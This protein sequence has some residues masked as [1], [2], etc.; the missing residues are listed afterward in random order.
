MKIKQITSKAISIITAVALILSCITITLN[1]FAAPVKFNVTSASPAIPLYVG[2]A[3]DLKNLSIQIGNYT[4]SGDTLTWTVKSGSSA[5]CQNGFLIAKSEGK[6]CFSVSSGGTK[7]NVW[8]I[9]NDSDNLDFSLINLDFSSDIYNKSDWVQ[10]SVQRDNTEWSITSGQHTVSDVITTANAPTRDGERGAIILTGA[11]NTLISKAAFYKSDIMEDFG[12]YTVESEISVVMAATNPSADNMLSAPGIITRG[13]INSNA[14]SGGYIFDKTNKSFVIRFRNYGGVALYGTSAADRKDT[15]SPWI[16]PYLSAHVGITYYSISDTV[17][18]I[19]SLWMNGDKSL[20]VYPDYRDSSEYSVR[21]IKLDLSGS[22]LKYTLDGNTIF[23]STTSV[24]RISSAIAGEYG[25]GDYS[26]YGDLTTAKYQELYK[27]NVNTFKGTVGITNNYGSDLYVYSL[28][29]SAA[30]IESQFLPTMINADDIGGDTEYNYDIPVNSRY[31]L[32]L[33]SASAV[34]DTV[35]NENYEIKNGILSVYGNISSV[36]VYGTQGSKRVNKTFTVVPKGT[37]TDLPVTVFADKNMTVI[38]LANS[39]NTYRL[40]IDNAEAVHGSITLTENDAEPK[41]IYNGVIGSTAGNEFEFTV[42]KPQTMKLSAEYVTEEESKASIYN[43]GSTVR[44]SE[45][46]ADKALRFLVRI[47]AVRGD[48]I[49][50][51]TLENS[52]KLGGKTVTPLAVGSLI[53]PSKL[54]GDKELKFADEIVQSIDPN[55]LDKVSVNSNYAKNIVIKN[56]AKATDKYSDAYATLSGFDTE[57]TKTFNTL[58]VD[59]ACVSYIWYK[60]AQGNYGFI[61]SD[62]KER[63][64]ND[65]LSAAFPLKETD[66]DLSGALINGG[67]NYD[68]DDNILTTSASYK[69]GEDINFSLFVKG[70]Y[71]LNWAIYKDDPSANYISSLGEKNT[72]DANIPV[73]SGKT[74]AG[75]NVFNLTTKMNKAGTVKLVASLADSYG[76]TV[77]YANGKDAKTEIVAAVNASGIV[78]PL[79]KAAIIPNDADTVLDGF[80]ETFDERA[81]K[82]NEVLTKNKDDIKS[83][84]TSAKAGENKIFDQA[85]CLNCSKVSDGYRYFDFYVALNDS[86]TV[87]P[88]DASDKIVSTIYEN[89]AKSSGIKE[90]NLRPATGTFAIPETAN[91]LTGIVAEYTNGDTPADYT[92]GMLNSITVKTN[93]HG[94]DNARANT[95]EKYY[96]ALLDTD[97]INGGI[98]NSLI[99]DTEKSLANGKDSYAYGIVY[100]D[101]AALQT[102]RKLFKILM[103]KGPS[104]V[105]VSGEGIGGWRA[106]QVAAF[107]NAVSE[108][109]ITSPDLVSVSGG[110]KSIDSE[111]Q[112]TGKA[113]RYFETALSAKRIANSMS[114]RPFTFTAQISGN[115]ADKTSPANGVLAVYSALNKANCNASVTLKQFIGIDSADKIY[116]STLKKD[117]DTGEGRR[118]LDTTDEASESTEYKPVVEGTSPTRSKIVTGGDFV[119]DRTEFKVPENLMTTEQYHSKMDALLTSATNKTNASTEYLKNLDTIDLMLQDQIV[120]NTEDFISK[121]YYTEKYYVAA[122]GND[123]NPGTSPDK[124]WKTIYKINTTEIPEGSLVSFKRGDRFYGVIQPKSSVDYGAYGVGFKPQICAS[125]DAVAKGWKWVETPVKNVWKLD[126]RF[127]YDAASND[128]LN[129]TL[130][131]ANALSVAVLVDKDGNQCQVGHKDWVSQLKKNYQYVYVGPNYNKYGNNYDSG[132][133][134]TCNPGDN[135]IYMYCDKGNPGD[136]F[137]EIQ[138]GMN[139]SVFNENNK[140]IENIHLRNLELLYGRG[141]IWPGNCK[142]ISVEYCT[143]GWSGGFDDG[144]QYFGNPKQPTPYGG[145]GGVYGAC[146]NYVWDHCYIFQQWDSGLSAQAKRNTVSGGCTTYKDFITT[147]CLI[148]GAKWSLELWLHVEGTTDD[149]ID[150]AVFDYN[151]IRD[152]GYGFNDFQTSESACVEMWNYSNTCRNSSIQHNVFDRPYDLLYHGINPTVVGGVKMPLFDYNVC[153]QTNGKRLAQV[154]NLGTVYFNDS[155]INSLQNFGIDKHSLFLY[156]NR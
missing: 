22:N 37:D 114:L 83:F 58:D 5:V 71:S 154:K 34:W 141:P 39:Q 42:F 144:T 50:E 24:S 31:N 116:L 11:Q 64:Y 78:S 67:T 100:R 54:L 76:N 136:I 123:N 129:F 17:K 81:I 9:V 62:K 23:D 70:A 51:A 137:S 80:A 14:A 94:F 59:I 2:K 45:N 152:N 130:D 10:G 86:V 79:E 113:I 119:P 107:D 111:N 89:A 148:K 87:I 88:A 32:A 121:N 68:L 18:T 85:L 69:T 139:S 122:D 19:D 150:H 74:Q 101:Y 112:Y 66:A 72:D 35:K 145:G 43:L 38:P 127:S 106:T 60:D 40:R 109:K 99:S 49:S 20:V 135:Y 52:I 104:R 103:Q 4:K 6:T 128:G 47:P 77:K 93:M 1:S 53:L 84:I 131:M 117:Y 105:T 33:E 120:Y 134:I 63:N 25:E 44:L 12:D 65:I 90:Y 146:D 15:S 155:G 143:C 41:V 46:D 153:I 149:I 57:K 110:K 102:A 95:E 91:S 75:E 13:H 7:Q 133:A 125:F 8:A 140:Y 126:N 142:N 138:I 132:F 30:N 98:K 92:G 55:S 56:L 124:P 151:I 61:Y 97:T 118:N 48:S 82:I 26:D 28:K 156:A 115:F 29:V 27:Q 108:L 96:N 73:L 147:N 3:V 16:A 36:T 21:K